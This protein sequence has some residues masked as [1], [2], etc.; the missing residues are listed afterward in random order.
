MSVEPSSV[1]GHPQEHDSV[2]LASGA[3]RAAAAV[4]I[5]NQVARIIEAVLADAEPEHEHAREMLRRQLAVY[6]DQPERALAEHLAA[7]KAATA[8]AEGTIEAINWVER[9]RAA[10]E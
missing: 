9:D 2:D 7:L 5:R 4:G 1:P 6:P 3:K 8:P 10:G